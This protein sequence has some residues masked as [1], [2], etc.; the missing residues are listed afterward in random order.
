MDSGPAAPHIAAFVFEG[1][2]SEP[3]S[4]AQGDLPEHGSLTVAQLEEAADARAQAEANEAALAAVEEE[5]VHYEPRPLRSRKRERKALGKPGKNT[6]CFL[7]SYV[8][9]RDT[10]LPADDVT[11]IVEMLR[12]NTGRMNSIALAQQVAQHYAVL[13]QRVNRQLQRGEVPLP[14]MPPATVLEHIRR[15]QQDMEVKQI[16]MLEELQEIRETLLDSVIEQHPKTKRV[17]GNM[18]QLS[19]LERVI[20]LELLVHSKDPSKMAMYSAGSRVNPAI[21]KQGIVATNTKTLYSYWRAQ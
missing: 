13:R 12:Q 18:G 4:P 17:R 7:C 10:T 20:K 2:G 15:H 11:K 1:F 6:E 9:E 14:D 21:H 3:Q 8:G 19:A 16:V 5:V